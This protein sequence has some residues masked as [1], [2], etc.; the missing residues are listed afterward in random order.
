MRIIETA[1]KAKI[2]HVIINKITKANVGYSD[3]AHAE[4]ELIVDKIVWGDNA[5]SLVEFEDLKNTEVI[6]ETDY[7]G[8]ESK[9]KNTEKIL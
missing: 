8:G 3:K 9:A 2:S 1:N 6:D 5:I 4:E 7:H